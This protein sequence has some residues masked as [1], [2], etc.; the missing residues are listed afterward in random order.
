MR[1]LAASV[2]LLVSVF[3]LWW[4]GVECAQA[5]AFTDVGAAL[6]GVNFSSVAWG[7]YDNDG[8]L[9]ILLA[10]LLVD[11]VTRVSKVYRNDAGSFV[12]VGAGLT[13]VEGGSAAWGDYDNDGDLDI[14]LT[15][16]NGTAYASQVYQNGAGVFADISASLTGVGGGSGLWADYDNDGDLDIL[17]TG[18]TGAAFVSKIYRND[19]GVFTD[20]ATS[21]TGVNAGYSDS[22]AAWGDYDNDGDLDI[23]LTGNSGTLVSN[24]Y[25]NTNGSFADVGAGLI[26]VESS[27]VAW[28]DY[29]NDGDLDIVLAGWNGTTRVS[30]VYANNGNGTFNTASPIDLSIGVDLASVAWG[31]YD[32]DGDLDILLV[33]WDGTTRVSKIYRNDPGVFA[34][35]GVSLALIAEGSVAWGDYDNDGDLDALL[36]GNYTAK[37]YRN[38]SATANTAP[39]AP[40]GLTA[41]VSGNNVTFSWTAASDSQTPAA[42][43]TYNLGLGTTSGGAQKV[44]PHANLATGYRRIPALG[45]TNHRTSWTIK[46]LAPGTY[47]WSVQAVDTAF[48]GSAFAAEQTAGVPAIQLSTTNVNVGTVLKT[49]SATATFTVTNSGAG[50]LSVTNITSDNAQFS[51]A[52]T[53]FS[54]GAAANQIVTVTFTPTKVGWEKATLSITHNAAGSPTTPT[55]EGIGKITPPTGDLARTKITFRTDR[56]GNF[57][58]YTVNSDGTSPL[59][60]TSHAALDS[61]PDWSPDGT[62]IAFHSGRGANEDIYVINADGSGVPTRLTTDPAEDASPAWS[63]DGTKIASVFPIGD[64]IRSNPSAGR[65]ARVTR[66][67]SPGSSCSPSSYGRSVSADPEGSNESPRC[68]S[69]SRTSAGCADDSEARHTPGI[70]RWDT[71]PQAEDDPQAGETS[72][73]SDPP[74]RRTRIENRPFARRQPS[75]SRRPAAWDASA[76][77]DTSTSHPTR[78]PSPGA[79]RRAM[80]YMAQDD[81]PRPSAPTGLFFQPRVDRP[82]LDAQHTADRTRPVPF[83]VER[84]GLLLDRLGVEMALRIRREAMMTLPTQ[85]RL[86]PII[87]AVL[88]DPVRVAVGTTEVVAVRARTSHGDAS[89]RKPCW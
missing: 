87:L 71:S 34:D 69:L 3:A 4:V 86:F 59:N 48:A 7:D 29:D 8:D 28:G 64:A 31:D 12:D 39:A 88:D 37:V 55:A 44:S 18:Y 35:S 82:D 57:E 2:F 53:S 61:N 23:L 65:S 68:G 51:A 78:S 17:L 40:I 56:D 10:G 83:T 25:Q 45:N 1:R 72:P 76:P 14:L 49:S 13:G 6:T 77:S 47:Y 16:W 27:A 58:V 26:G 5:Q 66:E 42:G 30:K 41:T 84:D 22:P 89:C 67:A 73:H 33:G 85:I 79:E 62:R 81:L 60:R 74:P 15:G 36:T 46:G 50:T 21:L 54:L 9:D 80:G 70:H 24:L 75:I 19:V 32:N 11:G 52:P 20:V 43:L 63:P 38:D